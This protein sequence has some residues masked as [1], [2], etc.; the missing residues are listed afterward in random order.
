M[1]MVVSVCPGGGAV[2]GADNALIPAVTRVEGLGD[3]GGHMA[4]TAADLVA[5]AART[6][7]SITA[8]EAIAEISRGGVLLLD[9]R[10]A[11]ELASQGRVPGSV[12]VPRGL[13]EF[14]ADPEH[15]DHQPGLEPGRR[16][17]VYCFD[18]ERSALAGHTLRGLGYRNVAYIKGGLGSWREAGGPTV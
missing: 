2:N 1:L 8:D 13:L 6:V 9:V 18:G 7:Q 17:V 3:T 4:F 16:V 14:C 15:R 10:E 12:W 5:Q 11:A